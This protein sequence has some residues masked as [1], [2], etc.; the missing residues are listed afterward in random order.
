MMQPLIL[1]GSV[2]AA[3]SIDD[4]LGVMRAG[5]PTLVQTFISK[6]PVERCDV[7]V[8]IDFSRLN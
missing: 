6:P 8:M 2:L 1:S 3:I 4:D 7:G 5:E